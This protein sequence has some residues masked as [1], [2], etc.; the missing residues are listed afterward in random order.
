MCLRAG[1]ITLS[2]CSHMLNANNAGRAKHL[3]LKKEEKKE[4]LSQTY[5]AL[6]QK[7]SQ[8]VMPRVVGKSL[9]HWHNVR[10]NAPSLSCC[11]TGRLLSRPECVLSDGGDGKQQ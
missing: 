6:L 9:P 3:I 1:S 5:S 4:K 7:F 11:F 10:V 8:P 2:Q